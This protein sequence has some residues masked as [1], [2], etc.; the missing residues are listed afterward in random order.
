MNVK[1]SGV[2]VIVVHDDEKSADDVR[3]DE[4]CE[5]G[6]QNQALA[7]D[8]CEAGRVFR[9]VA[10]ASFLTLF[11]LLLPRLQILLTLL[12]GL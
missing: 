5:D 4:G 7:S 8:T 10:L 9:A 3:N 2:V 11:L 1:L 6:G 12:P